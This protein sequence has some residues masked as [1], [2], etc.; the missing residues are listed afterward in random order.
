[1]VCLVLL[2]LL[3]LLLVLHSLVFALKVSLVHI[4]LVVFFVLFGFDMV[5]FQDGLISFLLDIFGVFLVIVFR[6]IFVFV[7]IIFVS[8]LVF[9]ELGIDLICVLFLS[10][11]LRFLCHL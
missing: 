7:V 9:R 3:A 6:A 5:I 2:V 1:M 10:V 11:L 4:L 8:A